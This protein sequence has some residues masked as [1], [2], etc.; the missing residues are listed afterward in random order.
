[1]DR[2]DIAFA[3]FSRGE[4]AG[5]ADVERLDRDP[6]GVQPV[7]QDVEAN[8]MAAD[9]DK[10]GKV[11]TADQL[12]LD[13]RAGRHVLGVLR[14]YDEP[15]SLTEGGDRTRSLGVR[16]GSQRGPFCASH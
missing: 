2:R 3:A 5:A 8:A 16:V 6:L 12:H 15:V 13:R 10:I 9:H 4:A 7:D 1:M 14:Q 11:G